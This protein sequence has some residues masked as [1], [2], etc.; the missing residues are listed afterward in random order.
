MWQWEHRRVFTGIF[1]MYCSDDVVSILY[2]TYSYLSFVQRMLIPEDVLKCFLTHSFICRLQNKNV[3]F[4]RPVET[5]PLRKENGLWCK[6]AYYIFPFLLFR[7]WFLRLLYPHNEG[8]VCVWGLQ[9]P[10]PPGCWV[11]L[12]DRKWVS[13]GECAAGFLFSPSLFSPLYFSLL[14]IWTLLCCSSFHWIHWRLVGLSLV[15]ILTLQHNPHSN[16]LT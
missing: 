5:L 11:R 3:L 4:W 10:L 13:C 14:S 9:P 8:S 16:L 7:K 6:C 1:T 12:T 2:N 15:F